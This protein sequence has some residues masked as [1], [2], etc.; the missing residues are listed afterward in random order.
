VVEP[1]DQPHRGGL[2]RAVRAEES[3]D[4][5]GLD[6]AGQV[7]DCTGSAE[8]LGQARKLDHARE[9]TDCDERRAKSIRNGTVGAA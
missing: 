9:T 4:H 5:A 6:R 7:V 1:E 8:H 2:A 3:G